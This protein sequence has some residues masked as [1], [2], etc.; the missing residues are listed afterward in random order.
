MLDV[1]HEPDL[2]LLPLDP[3]S[4]DGICKLRG[5][6]GVQVLKEVGQGLLV[7]GNLNHLSIAALR[8]CIQAQQSVT[9][10]L[11]DVI[12]HNSREREK[13]TVSNQRIALRLDTTSLPGL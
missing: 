12:L 10:S 3:V 1:L 13:P 7:P 4:D 8:R 5:F 6:F 9:A 11:V 2:C